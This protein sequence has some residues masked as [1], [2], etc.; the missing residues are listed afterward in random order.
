MHVCVFPESAATVVRAA[1]V[2]TVRKCG[3][4]LREVAENSLSTT[5]GQDSQSRAITQ[6]PLQVRRQ[7]GG[8]PSTILGSSKLLRH[9]GGTWSTSE[10]S[11][12]ATTTPSGVEATNLMS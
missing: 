7:S 2:R 11:R 4:E 6:A 3:E 9:P 10:V 8:R 12:G 1:L 5:I